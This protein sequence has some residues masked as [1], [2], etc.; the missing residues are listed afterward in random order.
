MRIAFHAPLKPPDHPVAS[1]ERTM[2]RALIAALG[3][4]GEVDQV[5]RFRSLE[6]VGAADRQQALMAEAEAEIAR[7]E[8]DAVRPDL[9]VTYH[10]Y[11]KAPDLLGPVLSRHF[12]CPYVQIES[13]RAR[14]RLSG[15][16]SRFAAAAEAASDAAALILY[17]T[18]HDAETLLRDRP[19]GQRLAHLRPFLPRADLPPSAPLAE[20]A[21]ILVAG[22]LRPGDKLASYQIIAETLAMLT[23][24]WRLEIAGDG[25]ARGDVERLMAPFGHRVTFLGALDIDGMSAAFRRAGLLLWPGVNEAF[26]MI[27]LEAQAAGLPVVAQNRPGVRDVLA[28]GEHPAPEDGPEALARQVEALLGDPALRRSDGESALR[29][30][31]RFHLLDTAANTLG[32]ELK[33]LLA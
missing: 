8:R 26:G 33:A 10:N 13:T 29:H 21:P 17:L 2:A 20:G 28:P 14:S 6:K 11:Y 7:I 15:P 3:R 1:G 30:V 32:A 19:E 27:Y 25:P 9:W 23:S 5:S 16:W 18:E 24:D 4:V 12:G 22:M 31:E